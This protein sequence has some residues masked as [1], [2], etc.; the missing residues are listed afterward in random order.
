[1][2]KRAT[3]SMEFEVIAGSAA[4]PIGASNRAVEAYALGVQAQMDGKDQVQVRACGKV[5]GLH[6]FSSAVLQGKIT[7][8]GRPDG[9]R[10]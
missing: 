1:M 3:R 7:P 9:G 10:R 4:E 8:S 6:E 2:A 5:Y